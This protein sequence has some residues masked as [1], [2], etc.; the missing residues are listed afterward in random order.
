MHFLCVDVCVCV[1]I[2]M[3]A[4]AYIVYAGISV[5]FPNPKNGGSNCVNRSLNRAAI[6]ADSHFYSHFCGAL[7]A[8]SFHIYLI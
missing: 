3:H 1:Y 7:R 6:V 2:S 8:L 4:Y 5:S